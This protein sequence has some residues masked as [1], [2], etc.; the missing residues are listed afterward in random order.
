MTR[1]VFIGSIGNGEQSLARVADELEYHYDAVEAFTFA[2]AMDTPERMH[3][4][5]ADADVFTQYTGMVAIRAAEPRSIYA[6][7]PPVPTSPKEFMQKLALKTIRMHM[8]YATPTTW[9]EAKAYDKDM[10]N[11]LKH[12]LLAN[13]RHI[14]EAAAFD[15]IAA[16]ND[17]QFEGIWTELTFTSGDIRIQPTAEQL[18]N[19][20]ANIRVIPGQHDEL[21]LRPDSFLQTV[22]AEAA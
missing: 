21:L 14:K 3:R 17:A 7:N 16:A 5:L 13:V 10:W 2:D 4:V 19:C 18:K 22:L 9:E 6:V 8:P 15:S 20:Y 12:H 1:A 11:E